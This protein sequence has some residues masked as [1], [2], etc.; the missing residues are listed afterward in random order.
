MST[1]KI[2]VVPITLERHPNADTLSI[3]KVYDYTVVC[4][5][6]NYTTHDRAAYVPI[7]TV[8]GSVPEFAFLGDKRRIKAARLR[9]IYSEGLLVPPRPHWQIGDD[10]TEELGCVKWEEP[11]DSVKTG[12]ESES[13][14]GWF[15]VYTDIENYKRY[16]WLIKEGEEVVLT[17]K[18]HGANGR[19]AYFE[20][21]LWVGSHKFAK[22]FD[23][24]NMWWRIAKQYDLE[25]KLKANPG[26]II[27]GEVYGQ[28]QDL[29]Y[30][31]KQNELFFR[32]FD[33]STCTSRRYL[34]YDEFVE[35][36]KKIDLPT[37]PVLYRGPWSK[38]LLSLAEGNTTIP[39][40][41]N[42]KEGFVVR[43]VKERIEHAGRCILKVISP[44]Y[45]LRKGGTEGH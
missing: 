25:T 43:P 17:E 24:N 38:E 4:K 30:G 20:D 36:A 32:L 12:G 19:D 26:Y 2:E 40:A 5:T 1:L 8:V 44:Q 16:S 22:R 10:V 11:E 14:P 34:D 27:H 33:I 28:V 21:R 23:E 3:V 41:S 6:E 7:D 42:M 31:A 9:G 29:K 15:H 18:L 45:R 35:L 39:G 13:Q 37:V